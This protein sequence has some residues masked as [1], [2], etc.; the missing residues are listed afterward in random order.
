MLID[1]VQFIK[2]EMRKLDRSRYNM[3]WICSVLCMLFALLCFLW[4]FTHTLYTIA[5]KHSD[6]ND[7]MSAE[8]LRSDTG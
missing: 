1:Q 8:Y 7:I 5:L 2:F 6:T 3:L 4:Y